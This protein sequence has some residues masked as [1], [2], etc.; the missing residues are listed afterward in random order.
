MDR[1]TLTVAFRL[2]LPV[3]AGYLFIGIAFALMLEAVG[4]GAFWAFLMS[5]T[6]FAGSAQ[7]I[8][9]ELLHTGSALVNVAL[10]TF[11]I[12]FRHVVYGLSMLEKFRGM[13]KKKFYMVFALTD[14]TY[15][16]LSSTCPPSGVKPKR[17]YFYVAGLNHLYWMIGSIAGG[18]VGSAINFNTQGI[19]FAMTALFVVIAVEQ[20]K[21]AKTHLPALIGTGATLVSLLLFGSVNML[22]PALFIIVAMLLL[23]R[24]KLQSATAERN[25]AA[26]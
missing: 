16:L 14:E 24:R 11:L 26:I 18:A 5:L 3:L 20:W 6:I 12:N 7:Y 19:E 9:V 8:G 17:F 21:S 25:D 1:G 4:Y 2:T 13:G 15:A 23:L 22:L 10:L